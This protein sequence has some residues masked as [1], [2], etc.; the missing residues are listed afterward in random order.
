MALPDPVGMQILRIVSSTRLISAPLTRSCSPIL[1]AQVRTSSLVISSFFSV[2]TFFPL[3]LC[4]GGHR[5]LI[6]L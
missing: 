1:I 6:M 3:F 2:V 5:A 4:F